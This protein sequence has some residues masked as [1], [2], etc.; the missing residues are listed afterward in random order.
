MILDGYLQSM[1]DFEQRNLDD[2]FAFLTSRNC[3]KSYLS[4][5]NGEVLNNGK[6]K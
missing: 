2:Q 4:S 5:T 3:D 1:I 6:I